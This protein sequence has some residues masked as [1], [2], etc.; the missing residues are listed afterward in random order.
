VEER[1]Q[2]RLLS[3]L[4]LFL[5]QSATHHNNDTYLDM[6]PRL[7]PRGVSARLVL[8]HPGRYDYLLRD[9]ALRAPLRHATSVPS[10]S[11]PFMAASTPA[12]A[13]YAGS[14]SVSSCTTNNSVSSDTTLSSEAIARW[15]A[16][17]PALACV[18]PASAPVH[19]NNAGCSLP[20]ASVLH[21]VQSYL[22]EE[23]LSGGYEVEAAQ[24]AQLRGVYTNLARLLCCE[25]REV[26]LAESATLAWQMLFHSIE[27]RT[28]DRILTTHAEYA[29]NYIAF[30][31]AQRRYGVHVEVIPHAA[32]GRLCVRWL[33]GALR[34][35]GRP[36]ADPRVRLVSV[37]HVPTNGGLVQPAA[38]V[39]ALCVAHPRALFLLDA[40]QSAGQLP[41]DVRELGC[42]MLTATGRKY[43]RGPRGTGFLYVQ[44]ACMLEQLGEPAFLDLH[45]AQWGPSPEKYVV[46]GDARRFENWEASHALRC[47]L[48]EAVRYYL[49]EVTPE[50]GW[51]RIRRLAAHLRTLLGA[52]EPAVQV[53]DLGVVER[54][55]VAE[56]AGTAEMSAETGTH[57]MQ[58]G[59]TQR[60]RATGAE[61]SAPAVVVEVTGSEAE[62]AMPTGEKVSAAAETGE[63][64][65]DQ[66]AD[67]RCG[68]VTLSVRGHESADALARVADYLRSEQQV[69]VSVSG[70]SS[71]LIDM[72]ERELQ[73]VLRVSVHYYNTE[74]EVER[75][76][77]AL[78]AFLAEEICHPN[79]TT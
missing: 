63:Q 17:T 56:G 62:E 64:A 66:Q 55:G 7:L 38:E 52:L 50:V 28:G 68:L 54:S 32:D 29:S 1:R 10:S 21:A 9:S 4:R 25:E 79:T 51:T 69:N 39:G 22:R 3:Q 59:W 75:F 36:G 42:D 44:R 78:Q 70:A 46:R 60:R 34:E 33:A 24:H 8:S 26:A 61:E 31:Q 6:L 14:C 20:T 67:H 13:R 16:D 77:R 27:F 41:L 43:L 23:A 18:P 30:L 74:Q 48:G 73:A 65:A 49:D 35:D 71:T 5:P 47:G 58:A 76:V 45:G 19:L 11:T 12:P 57:R 2:Q 53:R 72:R 15:R 37:S 40:C